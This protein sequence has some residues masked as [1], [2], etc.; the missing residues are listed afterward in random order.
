MIKH[1]IS[2][3]LLIMT[4]HLNSQ[5]VV[6]ET[7]LGNITIKLYDETPIHK[8]NF[9][10]LVSKNYYNGLLFHRVIKDFMIQT[11]DSNSKNAKPGQSL[12][13]G[14]ASYTIPAEFNKKYYHKK[15]ALAAARQGDNVNP[16]KESSGSQFYIVQGKILTGQRNG[17]YGTA[18]YA[19]KIYR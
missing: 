6:I 1:F 4:L 3:V 13:Y 7:T 2:F 16:N 9:L 15:G 11:G 18:Q 10:G 14:G 5:Q 12:G 17:L 8:E 19:H